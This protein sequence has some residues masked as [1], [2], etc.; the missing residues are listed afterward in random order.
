MGGLLF[1]DEAYELGKDQ[2]G[3]EAMVTIL[4]ALTDPTYKGMVMVLAGYEK[5]METMF[6]RN[7]G[8]FILSFLLISFS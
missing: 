4:D 8:L 1:I 7:S 5:D 6:A 2:F 3:N